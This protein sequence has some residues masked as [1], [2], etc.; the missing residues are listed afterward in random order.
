[1]AAS[2]GTRSNAG[3]KSA[4]QHFEAAC[5]AAESGDDHGGMGKGKACNDRNKRDVGL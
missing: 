2:M 5:K 4:A 1:M 3:A